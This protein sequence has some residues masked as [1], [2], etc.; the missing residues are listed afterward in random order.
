MSIKRST[1]YRETSS[2]F[3][4]DAGCGLSMI[5]QPRWGTK[6]TDLRL[7]DTIPALSPPLFSCPQPSALVTHYLLRGFVGLSLYRAGGRLIDPVQAD[8]DSWTQWQEELS[9]FSVPGWWQSPGLF[10]TFRA[11]CFEHNWYSRN[12]IKELPCKQGVSPSQPAT[13]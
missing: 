1:N 11:P 8:Q 4:R 9:Q 6:E 5:R 7:L 2:D 10:V 12:L 13:T 3:Y